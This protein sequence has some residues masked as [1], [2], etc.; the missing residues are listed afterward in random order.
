MSSVALTFAVPVWGAGYVR[1]YLDVCL[2]THLSDGNL[3]ALGGA[4]EHTY[5]LFTTA[6]DFRVIEASRAFERLRGMVR[7]EVEILSPP[8]EGVNKY[9]LKTSCYRHAFEAASGRGAAIF[10]LNADMVLA[11]GFVRRSA[12]LLER[13]VRLIE[14]PGPRGVGAAISSALNSNFRSADGVAISVSTRQLADLWLANMHP[15][16]AQHNVEGPEGEPFHPSHLYWLVEGEGVMI[17]GFHLYPIVVRPPKGEISFNGTIDDDLVANLNLRDH[18]RYLA[19]DS[20]E[21]FCCELSP[22]EYEVAAV[23]TRGN[24]DAIVDF[25]CSYSQQNAD[26]VRHEMII[27]ARDKLGPMWAEKHEASRRFVEHL[28]ELYSARLA[29]RRRD[30]L[31][32]PAINGAYATLSD[33]EA[34]AK[35]DG[36]MNTGQPVPI[37]LQERCLHVHLRTYPHR[38]DLL[39]RLCAILMADGRHVPLVLQARSLE[40]LLVEHPDRD[41]LRERLRVVRAEM[42]KLDPAPSG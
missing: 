18:E 32:M 28:L 42:G 26:N 7:V 34:L 25:Y 30:E 22:A 23:T 36:F 1:T 24:L 20:R 6:D 9:K 17:R 37:D 21:L 4:G 33:A 12:E 35:A 27:T 31:E 2:P 40:A 11:D 3:G 38:N 16:L 19:A 41:D 13:G 29:Q 14:V 8:G 15:Q 10:A 5:T 39:Q